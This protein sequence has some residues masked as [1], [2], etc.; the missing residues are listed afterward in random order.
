[1]ISGVTQEIDG[2]A[3]TFRLTTRAMMALEDW[4]NAARDPALNPVSIA[5]ILDGMEAS[6]RVGTMV[7]IVRECA[8]DGAGRDLA[9]AQDAVDRIGM[10]ATGQLVARVVEAAF[11][12]AKADRAPGKSKRA[13]RRK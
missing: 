5:D 11:P 13:T 10:G 9:W 1:M 12:E 8:D 7:R 4:A 2:R 3:E 6:P